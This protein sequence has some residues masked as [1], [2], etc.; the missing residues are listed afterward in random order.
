MRDTDP[1]A[2][3][4]RNLA[5]ADRELAVA[6][7]D[8]HESYIPLGTLRRLC[9]CAMCTNRPQ[10]GG[11][12]LKIVEGPRLDD[13]TIARLVPVGAYAVQIVWSDGHDTGIYSYEWLRSLCPCSEC[14]SG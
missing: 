13:I 3:K 1:T 8:G 2:V 9:P 12:P 11:A 4:P 10:Q 5:I 6:W 14:A 7:G